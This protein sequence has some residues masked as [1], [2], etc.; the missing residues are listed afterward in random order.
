MRNIILLAALF[1]L[2]VI[3][4]AQPGP[5]T[6]SGG[7]M[8]F[9]DELNLTDQQQKQIDQIRDEAMRMQIDRRAEIAK[10][11]VDLRQ[12][13]KA[14]KPDQSA[15]E[16][17]MKEIASLRSSS[18]A[19]RLNTWFTINKALTPEQQKVWKDA[20]GRH[21]EMGGRFGMRNRPQGDGFRQGR[22]MREFDRPMR[23][24][25]Q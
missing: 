7:R 16:K 12:L 23:R 6:G 3:A 20:L 13:V 24:E 21:M 10:L 11:R 2:P 14:D 15:I 18:E 19:Q 17:K 22:G 25:N 5:G 9:I 1:F 4:I 8:R